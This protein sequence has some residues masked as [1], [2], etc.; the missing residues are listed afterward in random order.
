MPESLARQSCESTG[1]TG[2]PPDAELES[3]DIPSINVTG[4]TD[5]A[6]A[7][8]LRGR[9][10]PVVLH[11]LLHGSA[12]LG[13]ADRQVFLDEFG[14]VTVRSGSGVDF[15]KFGPEVAVGTMASV[16]GEPPDG[17]SSTSW[18]LGEFAAA[19]RDGRAG[20]DAYVFFNVTGGAI[21]LAAP[22]LASL[23]AASAAPGEWVPHSAA[24]LAAG[25]HSY[26]SRL[27]LGGHGSGSAFHQH[28]NAFSALL[29]R[30]RPP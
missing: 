25:R 3:C 4:L 11:G 15:G 16:R 13:W 1:W 23:W 28:D 30:R 20:D 10:V 7:A 19:L 14:P 2:P 6:I 24:D 5:T 12:A 9:R 18:T 26:I 22:R 8:R 21:D 29:V 27:S 17:F